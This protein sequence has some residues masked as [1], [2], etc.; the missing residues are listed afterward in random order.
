MK[1]SVFVVDVGRFR[2]AN[3]VKN[4]HS[5]LAPLSVYG[6]VFEG[7]KDFKNQRRR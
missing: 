6:F 5:L 3:T 1:G 2:Q 7:L 4:I